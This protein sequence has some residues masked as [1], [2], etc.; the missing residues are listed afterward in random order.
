M[1]NIYSNT[2]FT[3]KDFSN[4]HFIYF[5]LPQDQSLIDGNEF[6]ERFKNDPNII[7]IIDKTYQDKNIATTVEFVSLNNE[8]EL[9]KINYNDKSYRVLAGIIFNQDFSNYTIRI[10]GSDIV[11]SNEDA[12]MDFG[13]SRKSEYV[14]DTRK[15]SRIDYPGFYSDLRADEL[16]DYDDNKEFGNTILYYKGYTKADTYLQTFIPIQVAI[17]NII[18]QLK[19]NGTVK[20]Y[21]ANVG[22]L[23]KP[24]IIFSLD[25]E[26]NVKES[27][28]GYAQTLYLLFVAPMLHIVFNIMK[29]KESGIRDGFISIGA[30]RIVLWLSWIIVYLPFIVGTVLFT[31][32]VDPTKLT[33]AINKILF[34]FILF[35]YAITTME[36]SV[37]FCFLFKNTKLVILLI[38]IL[39]SILYAI[40]EPIY[41]LKL[42]NNFFIIEKILSL[43]FS[44][45]GI[46]MSSSILTYEYNNSGFIGFNNIFKNEYGIY[47]LF[48]I[49]DVVFYFFII[50]FVDSLNDWSIK[51]F[52]I[53][54]LHQESND[55]VSHAL[56]IQEDP[57]GTECFVQVRNIY[58]YFKFKKK[59]MA[60]NIND[61]KIG[62]IFTVNRN[63]SFN[64]YKDEI[65]AILGHNGAGKSTLIK[66]MIGMMKPECGEVFYNGLPFSQ[67]KKA[68]Q[69]HMGICLQNNILIDEFTVAEHYIL[70]TGI[71]EV[72]NDIE[73]WLKDIDLLEKRDYQVKH[74]STGQK[75]KLSIGL[76]FIGDPKYVFLD[77]PTTGLDPLSRQKIWSLLMRKKRDR[78]IFITTHYMDE[79]D[80]IAD[81][82]LILNK[83][84][85]RCLGSS[86]Y[87]KNHFQMRYNL[88]VETN[89]RQSV[90]EIIKYYVP[91]AEYYNV[92]TKVKENKTLPANIVSSHVWKLAIDDSPL[93]SYLIKHLEE[94]K[95]KGNILHNYSVG[96][97]R[98]EELFVYLNKENAML[99]ETKSKKQSIFEPPNMLLEKENKPENQLETSKVYAIELPNNELI[100]KPNDIIATLRLARYRIKFNY[101]KKLFIGIS[102][103]LPFIILGISFR[104][105]MEYYARFN[106]SDFE[107][108]KISSEMY[109]NQ[110]WNYDRDN[111]LTIQNTL[112]PEIFK[113]SSKIN[114]LTTQ[115]SNDLNRLIYKGDKE[116]FAHEPYYVTSFS[117]E[118]IDNIY[119]FSIYYNDSMPHAL[120]STLNSLSNAILSS[121]PLSNNV[122]IQVNSYPLP[123]FNSTNLSNF[124]YYTMLILT[125]FFSLILSLYSCN[126]I[127]ER[128]NKL[129]KQLQL[130]GISNL[131][132]WLSI[133]LT[134]YIWFLVSSSLVII[135][136]IIFKFEP[137]NCINILI[138][139]G[140]HF[141]IDGISCLLYQ[142]A[143][144]FLFSS[145][146]A[147][148]MASFFFNCFPSFFIQITINSIT[149][150]NSLNINN[151]NYLIMDTLFPCYGFLN[152]IKNCILVGVEHISL[153][154]D[155]VSYK[156]LISSYSYENLYH[157]I[158]SILSIIVYSLLFVF[159][160]KKL[161]KPNRE[162][163]YEI[164]KEYEENIE[165]DIKNQ[166]EDVYYEYERVKSDAEANE[167]PIKLVNLLKEYNDTR[168]LTTN[169]YAKAMK[170]SRAK[171]GEFHTSVVGD[172]VCPYI[173][174]TAFENI[175]LGINKCECF[176]LLGPNGSGKTSL[177]NTVSFTFKQTA[178][179]IFFEGKNTL[180]RKANEI[181]L[182]YCPQENTLW[183]EMTLNEH[184]EMFLYIRGCSRAKSKKLAEQFIKYC[185]LTPHKNKFPSEMS[186]GTRRKLNIL[187]ALCCNSSRVLLDEPSA[188]MDPASRRYIWDVIKAT[189]QRNQSSM[190]MTTH[191]MEEA[192]L[193]CNR[194]GIIVN[195]RLQCIGTPEH[196]KMKFGHT[197]ILDVHTEN[198][199]RFHKEVVVA[200]NLFGL[201]SQYRRDNVS[202]HRVK[203]E[204]QHTN[205]RDI[206]RVFEIM[207]ASR[208]ICV[209]G[210]KIYI[211]YSYSQTTLEEV[212]IKFARLKD[213]YDDGDLMDDL[214]IM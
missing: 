130:N 207:E 92:K 196:L 133:F 154:N 109:A 85:I 64:V 122:T 176:G 160:M 13:K 93:F 97:P 15:V 198:V 113:E 108:H 52:G 14:E 191:S 1:L 58:K 62:K 180:D 125:V 128:I 73:I 78:V 112:N 34:F 177:L 11:N 53:K 137:L 57:F 111:S 166:D 70:Y 134:D 114:I 101:R 23:S 123:Y 41:S 181:T 8:E 189:I 120:P 163:V 195:G 82:K 83:G 143:F 10:K 50:I 71:K 96:A 7:E 138:F 94:E 74:L 90:E 75:R 193:I 21:T 116:M 158:G 20:G 67:N 28:D 162:D 159:I 26:D 164:T 126:I 79:A 197:Y 84:T 192:E 35:L 124:T 148:F 186:G 102:I 103:I 175:N 206:S 141:S 171:Y 170:R 6:I 104:R 30:N 37:I 144:S 40:N 184:I 185:R 76:A 173:V 80:I 167:I 17:D 42:D 188:G 65:F 46:S 18:I 127:K 150:E 209:N 107:K 89:D 16:L 201:K 179:D 194:I 22:K 146:N 155:S 51:T 117:G 3:G 168:S 174:T 25:D 68:I 69:Y 81:R 24:S 161:H 55:N 2:N 203:Y 5:V 9:E 147:V 157:I 200:F 142:Y 47:I 205:T 151:F 172:N 43:L 56:D 29:E 145:E 136:I 45:I 44:P 190:I 48:M 72:I 178:G 156:N 59:Y 153:K 149:E 91:E 99:N 88:E 129:L 38:A 31:I 211:D 169:E 132:Y 106:F 86:V 61:G 63:I 27:F 187:I 110:K 139:L 49:I 131:S 66:I 135:S 39:M 165:K 4:N 202:Q 204:I 87:L 60:N 105:L 183:E 32:I 152:V 140:L 213:N 33:S 98:L 95:Q 12:V 182:G 19:T 77:E 100:K 119:N 121:N 36:I 118:L 214:L 54:S 208:D 199:E 210:Q 212:F 115:Q